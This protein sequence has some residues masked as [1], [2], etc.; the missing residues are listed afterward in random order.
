M[1]LEFTP[2]DERFRAEVR[3][4]LETEL[5]GD[6]CD[7]R[8]RGGLPPQRPGGRPGVKV[9][10]REREREMEERARGK[11]GEGMMGDKL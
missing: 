9:G 3:D 10:V 2:A 1:D 5:S 11:G 8:G 4:W 7:V 6:F